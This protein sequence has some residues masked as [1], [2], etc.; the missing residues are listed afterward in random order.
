MWL[1]GEE[2]SEVPYC[3]AFRKGIPFD[4]AY[5]SNQHLTIDARQ[6]GEAVFSRVAEI[7]RR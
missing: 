2:P 3:A 4:I 7:D 6:S 5:G 1:E